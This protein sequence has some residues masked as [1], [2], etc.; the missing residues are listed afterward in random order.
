MID[1]TPD[2][3]NLLELDVKLV[4]VRQEKSAISTTVNVVTLAIA[5]VRSARHTISLLPLDASTV[6]HV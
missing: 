4:T 1:A 6:D 5:A 3:L 2:I